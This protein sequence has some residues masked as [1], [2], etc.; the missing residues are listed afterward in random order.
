MDQLGELLTRDSCEC[1]RTQGD[2]HDWV[3]AVL[4]ATAASAVTQNRFRLRQ[5]WLAKKFME[6]IWPLSLV[7]DHC[8]RGRKDVAFRPVFGSGPFDAQI[9]DRSSSIVEVIPLE[10]TQAHYGEEMYHRM[11]HLASQG[12]VPLTGPLTKRGTRATGISVKTV[13]ETLDFRCR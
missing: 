2:L 8:Y 4:L 11:L 5:D 10:F 13:L 1:E 3:H 12:H 7:A 6:E 9:L